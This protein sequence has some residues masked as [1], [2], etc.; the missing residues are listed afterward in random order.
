MFCMPSSFPSAR[1]W[2]CLAAL[3]AA[4][5]SV[6]AAAAVA[7]AARHVG[8]DRDLRHMLRRQTSFGDC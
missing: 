3:D 6:F 4:G 5:A 7:T 2:G 1:A 8:I